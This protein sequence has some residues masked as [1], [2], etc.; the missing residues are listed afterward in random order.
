[1]TIT[2]LFLIKK[3]TKLFF[4]ATECLILLLKQITGVNSFFL[5]EVVGKYEFC[6]F[7]GQRDTQNIFGIFQKF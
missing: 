7:R 3:H 1:M 6:L 2:Y 4:N 5:I